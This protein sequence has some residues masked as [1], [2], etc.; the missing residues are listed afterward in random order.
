MKHL[1]LRGLAWLLH[2]WL[3]SENLLIGQVSALLKGT[4]GFVVSFS[5]LLI[6]LKKEGSTAIL[7]VP[8]HEIFLHQLSRQLVLISHVAI[9][10]PLLVTWVL[11]LRVFG[12]GKNLNGSYLLKHGLSLGKLR[13]L[14]KLLHLNGTNLLESLKFSAIDS[15]AC[16]GP[17]CGVRFQVGHLLKD[18]IKGRVLIAL[19]HLSIEIVLDE[20]VLPIF[21]LCLS[22][23]AFLFDGLLA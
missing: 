14:N 12:C 13:C 6:R 7:G 22:C 8:G 9:V 19:V 11:G 16:K 15:E 21:I 20:I 1:Q 3:H 2:L 10:L 5:L 4:Q 23:E 18:Q 17:L